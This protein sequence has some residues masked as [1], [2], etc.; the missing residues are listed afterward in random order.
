MLLIAPDVKKEIDERSDRKI[1]CGADTWEE[2]EGIRCILV[3]EWDLM[4]ARHKSEA[5]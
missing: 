1:T 4:V 2:P 5:A 3:E